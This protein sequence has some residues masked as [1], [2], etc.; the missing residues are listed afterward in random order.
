MFRFDT[1]VGQSGGRYDPVL[2]PAP[3]ART[4]RRLTQNVSGRNGLSAHPLFA[5]VFIVAAAVVLA[6]GAPA[7]SGADQTAVARIKAG[8]HDCPGCNLAGAD[9]SNQCVKHGDLERADFDGANLSVMCMSYGD[10]RSASFR[11]ADLSG[12]NLAHAR[13][14]GADVGGAEMSI[15]SLR[16]TDLRRAIGLSQHQLDQACGDLE[17]KVPEGMTVHAC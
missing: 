13:L 9:L 7:A 3:P 6:A 11:K 16:G 12:A 1:K 8:A 2:A 15:T 14:D 4:L 10:F 17:T 5:S